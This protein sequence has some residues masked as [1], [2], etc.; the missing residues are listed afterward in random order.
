MKRKDCDKTQWTGNRRR[1]CHKRALGVAI[2]CACLGAG[3]WADAGSVRVWSSAVVTTGEVRLGDVCALRGFDEQERTALEVVVVSEAPAPGASVTLTQE[4][5]RAA[6][7]SSS[8][9]MAAITVSG[10]SRCRVSRPDGPVQTEPTVEKSK[11]ITARA[12]AILAAD[13]AGDRPRSP[14]TLRDAVVAFFDK[15]LRRYDGRAQVTFDRTAEQVLELAAPEYSFTV[16]RR[17]TAPLGLIPIQV[18]VS[19]NG[20]V[21]QTIPLVVLVSM[22]RNVVV[23][24]R[25]INA[26]ATIA[27]SDL[28][29][30]DLRFKRTDEIGLTR[31]EQL[32]G[33]RAKRFISAG[34][35]LDLTDVESVP[36]VV[37]GQLIAVESLVGGVKV[38]TTAKVTEDG[39]LG[40]VVTV[41]STDRKRVELDGVVIGVGRVR[42]GAPQARTAGAFNLAKAGS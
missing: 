8:V 6:L 4:P 15:E 5:I 17:G 30:I 32:I 29:T 27:A 24:E 33:Q 42:L 12:D 10:A 7:A 26:D 28:S 23:A 38:V 40:E 2:L 14:G 34:T 21:V 22:I 41:R 39:R 31:P 35:V 37:R 25:A 11:T 20:A 13:G 1:R 9:N 16:R 36:L 18:D 19:R 3:E